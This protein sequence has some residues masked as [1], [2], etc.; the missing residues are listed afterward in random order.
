MKAKKVKRPWEAQISA[1]RVTKE[2]DT[3]FKLFTAIAIIVD[4]LN[5]E[6][7]C[8]RYRCATAL[9][10]IG[11]AVDRIVMR[12]GADAEDAVNKYMEGEEK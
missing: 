12:L 6:D 1:Y 8:N 7:E 9:S 11:E 10:G 4:E 3:L 5:S 2:M